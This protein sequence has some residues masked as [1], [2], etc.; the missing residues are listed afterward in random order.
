MSFSSGVTLS[1]GGS[2]VSITE[3]SLGIQCHCSN[4]NVIITPL[5]CR[6]LCWFAFYP[7]GTLVH[8]SIITYLMT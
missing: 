2:K 5:S 3:I 7:K 4:G 6:K 8:D 1:A